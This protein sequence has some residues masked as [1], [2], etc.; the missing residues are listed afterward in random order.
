MQLDASHHREEAVE[1]RCVVVV[2]GLQSWEVQAA[3]T[4]RFHPHQTVVPVLVTDGGRSEGHVDLVK[5]LDFR[6]RSTAEAQTGLPSTVTSAHVVGSLGSDFQSQR[7]TLLVLRVQQT[8]G[9]TNDHAAHCSSTEEFRLRVH[10]QTSAQG[11][12]QRGLFRSRQSCAQ[13]V[14]RRQHNCSVFTHSDEAAQ[15]VLGGQW[16]PGVIDDR[17]RI[18]STVLQHAVQVGV[19]GNCVSNQSAEQSFRH[20]TVGTTASVNGRGFRQ[21]NAVA[22]TGDHL[23][24]LVRHTVRRLTGDEVEAKLFTSFA[25]KVSERTNH[26]HFG[27][28]EQRSQ[29]SHV[30]VV[31]MQSATR[32]PLRRSVLAGQVLVSLDEHIADIQLGVSVA[33]DHVGLEAHVDKL[34]GGLS[35]NQ[36]C[37][38]ELISFG[39]TRH[40]ER[41]HLFVGHDASIDRLLRLSSRSPQTEAVEVTVST[42]VRHAQIHDG[43]AL[44]LNLGGGVGLVTSQDVAQAEHVFTSRAG[45]DVLSNPL[46]GIAVD[47]C[48]SSSDAVAVDIQL[49]TAVSVTL[50]ALHL[51]RQHVQVQAHVRRWSCVGRLHALNHLRIALGVNDV[52]ENRS[53]SCPWLAQVEGIFAVHVGATRTNYELRIDRTLLCVDVHFG[54]VRRQHLGFRDQ[55]TR[56][57]ILSTEHDSHWRGVDNR[58]RHVW[59]LMMNGMVSKTMLCIIMMSS[60]FL[61]EKCKVLLLC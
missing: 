4:K 46:D 7:Q 1:H 28:I 18:T 27:C 19:F 41:I 2:H 22:G 49:E 15:S 55:R 8:A 39:Q 56:T 32:T 43:E 60:L 58:G 45:S 26:R 12:S 51:S 11:D 47:R 52:R 3:T 13:D 59:F 25:S 31:Q 61:P 14:M 50:Q 44:R 5:Q 29:V 42:K 35:F 21:T 9:A 6:S 54:K 48:T 38:R 20:R 36:F 33:V 16:E 34:L 57:L 40:A 30:V 53:V 10:L 37:R 17:L 24:R 23:E